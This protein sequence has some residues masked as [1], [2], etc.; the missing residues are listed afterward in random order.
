MI[1]IRVHSLFTLSNSFVI[2]LYCSKFYN[3][4]KIYLKME[5]NMQNYQKG[6]IYAEF[7]SA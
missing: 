1:T 3:E 4:P 2:D 5:E 6:G 7:S